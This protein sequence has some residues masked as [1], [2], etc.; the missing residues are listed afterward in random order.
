MIDDDFPPMGE[1]SGLLARPAQ[2]GQ[3]AQ[4]GPAFPDLAASA[5]TSGSEPELPTQPR[6]RRSADT[7]AVIESTVS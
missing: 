2:S 3:P 6:H 1:Q 5:A 7:P 4:Q